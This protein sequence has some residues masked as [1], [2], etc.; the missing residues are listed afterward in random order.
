V[1]RN[2][3]STGWLIA[4]MYLAACA[5]LPGVP[6]QATRADL[7]IL[8]GE[9]TGEYESAALGRSGSVEFRLNADTNEASGAVL[10]VPRGQVQPYRNESPDASP[11]A[12]DPFNK[13]VL[14]IRFVHASSGSIL[15]MLERY[16]DPDRQCFASTVFRGFADHN[17]VKGTFVTTFDCGAGDATG[18]WHVTKKS[19]RR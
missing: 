16:W 10:M 14:T 12:S 11:V 19:A 7:E 13:S 9:W 17:V 1:F 8:A 18:S 5:P 3:S 2:L 15:G 4:L 6:L